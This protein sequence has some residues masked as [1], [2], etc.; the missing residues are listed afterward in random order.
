MLVFP[1]Q[2]FMEDMMG[3]VEDEFAEDKEFLDKLVVQFVD[4]IDQADT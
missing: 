4:D 1:V 3:F 2:N